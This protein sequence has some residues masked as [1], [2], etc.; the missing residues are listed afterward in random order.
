M[1]DRDIDARY[2][3]EGRLSG[4]TA[5][6][7]GAPARNRVEE[8]RSVVPASPPY[9]ARA[10]ANLLLDRAGDLPITHIA[11]QKL[12]FFAHGHYLLTRGVPLIAG[13]FEAWRYGPVHPVIYQAFKSAGAAAVRERATSFDFARGEPRELLPPDD[14]WAVEQI[15]RVLATMGRWPVSRLVELSHAPKGPWAET[16]NKSGTDSVLGLQISDK[17]LVERFRFHMVSLSADQAHGELG[18][19]SPFAGHGPRADRTA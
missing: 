2:R 16:V 6:D 7:P 4:V 3:P 9:D 17:V 12:L 11:L 5:Y 14:P 19:D 10:V 13:V 8:P 1:Q 18:E 15:D